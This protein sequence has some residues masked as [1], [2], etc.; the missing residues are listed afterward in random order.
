MNSKRY[1]VVLSL[2]LGVFFPSFLF[3]VIQKCFPLE[4]TEVTSTQCSTNSSEAALKISVL[5]DDEQVD[6]MEID[7]YLIA[8]VLREMPA[9]FE[10]EAL[11]AQAVVSR[12]YALRRLEG[13]SKH[14]NAAVCTD[15]AC[16]QG[17]IAPENYVAN[18][19]DE[20][21]IDR[22]RNAVHATSGQVLV[23]DG[24]LIDA[25]YFSCSGG[26]TE[27]AQAVW[28]ADVPYLQS[29]ESPG[30]EKADHYVDTVKF[31]VSDFLKM[32]ELND[33]GDKTV[34]ISDLTYTA[35]SGVDKLTINGKQ[36]LGTKLRK[37]LNLRS[38]MFSITVVGDT[39]TI[40]T[41]G[42]GHRVG[43][44]QYGAEAMAVSGSNFQDIL[45]HY[46]QGTQLV[47]YED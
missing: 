44:S 1:V 4:N 33:V 9:S 28:G 5:I 41:K 22:V 40:T 43:M 36:M 29:I 35:G 24:E 42:Y 3:S 46:Y 21:M 7:E 6:E 2:L 31:S 47:T 39:V 27:D 15:S 19:G 37:I 10:L 34:D 17:Y 32:L 11:K 14:D 26:R 13:Y 16:C 25:T 8:V 18:G 45:F 20:K 12:T 30:E 23:F 38:T